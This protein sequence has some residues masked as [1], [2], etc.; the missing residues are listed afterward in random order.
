[1]VQLTYPGVYIREVPSGARTITGV[2]TAIAAF[3]GM[4]KDGP[5][6]E[7]TLVLGFRDYVRTF[8][9][10][11][12]Q[13]E[14]TDQVRQFFLNGGQQAYITRIARN[15][16]SSKVD[17]TTGVSG[18]ALR[19][20]AINPGVAGDFL[21][22]TVDYG[23]SNPE[24][25][26]NLT[27]FRERV[28]A[29]GN[30]TV[31]Q[32]ETFGNLT[33]DPAGVGNV[34]NTLNNDSALVQAAVVNP[35]TG[36][37]VAVTGNATYSISA[38]LAAT[39]TALRDLVWNQIPAS[40][41]GVAKFAI[42][43]G[44]SSA[45]VSVTQAIVAQATLFSDLE[46][47]IE[48]TLAL[49]S[50]T[51]TVE[52][53][54]VGTSTGVFALKVSASISSTPVE[55]AFDRAPD[56]DITA[57]LGLGVAQGGI[58]R[59]RY[60]DIRPLPNGLVSRVYDTTGTEIELLA[61]IAATTRANWAS[62][63]PI[64][65]LNGGNTF[66]V[67]PGDISFPSTTAGTLFTGTTSGSSL[68]NVAENLQAIVD[69]IN[70]NT[71]FWRASLV[72]YR[73]ALRP[74]NGPASAGAAHS[75]AAVGP[76][77]FRDAFISP[78][79]SAGTAFSGGNDGT[80]PTLTEYRLAFDELDKVD[81][82]NILVLP[83]SAGDSAT[84]GDR[85]SFWGEASSRVDTRRA[86]LLIDAPNGTDSV[87]DARNAVVSLRAGIVK[88]HAAL[89]WPRVRVNPDGNA[90]FID[91][92]GSIAGVMSRIDSSRGVWK[93]PAGL[94]ADLRA[95]LDIEVPM[96]DPENGTLNPRA[97]NVIRSFT[98]GIVSW[99][100]R[101]MDG[102]DNSGN[103]DYKYVPV[104]RFALFLEESLLRGLKF[105]VFEPNDEPL[106]GQIR[107]AAGAFL[108]NLFRLG[109]FAGKSTRDSYFVKCDS[110][111]TTQNDI[112]LGIV[113]VLIGFAPLK[114]AEFVVITIQQKAGQ[115]QV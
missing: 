84:P 75:W 69:G 54:E 1:M 99:G 37:P 86:F 63:S 48:Q 14:M 29:S 65:T 110:E 40:S 19:L 74:A 57:I 26:F 80:K 60:S 81:I 101:T 32:T 13:G 8:S 59:G 113:N 53:V 72:G 38:A 90:R 5:I 62:P 36:L 27:V 9:E 78:S 109:A 82:Y 88:D 97:L 96:S 104:R 33:M 28:D 112:N 114:P 77:A 105:A 70:K 83:R 30:I 22:A 45:V 43:V 2:A 76:Q 92:S 79:T 39:S 71:S 89:Y 49:P 34:V 35:T 7:P 52:A 16:A 93:A 55:V 44:T 51:M 46:T 21:R 73:V 17:L 103:D 6:N 31:V 3:V 15:T 10:D 47:L 98:N 12:S 95:V 100:A 67:L 85:I 64:L 91:P 20:T 87:V 25:T 111:T 61:A 107:L 4:A 56:S 115:V 23:T 94:E 18:V 68:R 41:V 42:R 66:S 11:T 102:F 106:W 24:S 50:G 58:E 108:N